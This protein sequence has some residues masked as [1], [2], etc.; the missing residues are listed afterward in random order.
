MKQ[1]LARL[2]IVLLSI[3]YLTSQSTVIEIIPTF[4]Q[5][6]AEYF[7]EFYEYHQPS[8]AAEF[9]GISCYH[10]DVE[11]T[12]IDL[13]YR[14]YQS[15]AWTEWARLDPQYEYVV[16]ERRS[17]RTL[18]ISPDFTAI[19]L[20]SSDK[21]DSEIVVRLF[22]GVP[23][24]LIAPVMPRAVD[25][26]LPDA[27]YRE[28]WCPSCPIDTSPEYTE[29][30]HLIVHHSAG[31]NESSDYAIVVQYIWDLHVNTNGWDDIG[32]NWLIDPNGRLYEGRP[33]GYQG[34]HFSCI[35]EHTVGI[36]VI[37]D[38]TAI[39]PSEEAILT[40][41][42]VLAHEATTH[43]IDVTSESY[44]ETGDFILDNI[45]GHRDSSESPNACSGTECPGE[46]FYPL[47]SEIRLQ[48]AELPCYGG[49]SSTEENSAGL[50]LNVYPNPL[51]GMLYLTTNHTTTD[52]YALRD[53][54]GTRV[55]TVRPEIANDVS[56][57]KT[58]I[59][60]VT[61]D[62]YLLKTIVVE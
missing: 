12:E 55:G 30:T 14:R 54:H 62:G 34:A 6:G 46:S 22:S 9:V 24:D 39:P 52:H 47:L 25:C 17:Y 44:H 33:D 3:G 41:V 42:N 49:V 20:R 1:T 10:T 32:Y 57:L 23:G 21:V 11:G 36:C 48:V 26:D 59:Y 7:S 8:D 19:Q 35:N 2:S 27:C 5:E 50:E 40:L 28:C 43:A 13:H 56:Y 37:G 18:P 38:Y 31:N 61:S 53:I 16:P 58:G 45:A 15:G 29:P 60:F 51:N 4:H